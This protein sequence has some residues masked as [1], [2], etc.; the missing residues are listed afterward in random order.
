MRD[1]Y[2]KQ[3]ELLMRILQ[4]TGEYL[5]L[6]EKWL[7]YSIVNNTIVIFVYYTLDKYQLND[8]MDYG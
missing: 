6:S 8:V 7:N 3:V 5:A 4:K 1:K 2:R